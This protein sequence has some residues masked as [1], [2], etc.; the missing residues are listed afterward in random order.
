L[1]YPLELIGGVE[2]EF[3]IAY[4]KILEETWLV[5][6]IIKYV[7]IAVYV[8][9]IALCA[10]A[11]RLLAEFSWSKSFLVATVAYFA[12]MLAENFILGF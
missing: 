9:T 2:G 5:S 7:Q 8:W 3:E 10:I 4:S 12:S 1:Y 11:T 6:Q